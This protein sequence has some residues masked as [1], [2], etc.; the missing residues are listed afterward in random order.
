MVAAHNDGR[1]L[2]KAALVSLYFPCE[3]CSSLVLFHGIKKVV[4]RHFQ[5]PDRFM[6]KLLAHALKVSGVQLLIA[7]DKGDFFPSPSIEGF[8]MS[9]MDYNLKNAGPFYWREVTDKGYRQRMREECQK[10]VVPA[11]G[12]MASDVHDR[13]S[14]YERLFPIE[15][16]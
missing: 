15:S 11:I 7:D 2:S 3:R 1:D 13:P 14:I 8:A 5:H 4:F 9:F 12:Q 10:N 16:A 6:E